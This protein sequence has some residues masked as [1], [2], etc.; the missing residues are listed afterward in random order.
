MPEPY[1]PETLFA[2][3]KILYAGQAV[4]LVVASTL[5]QAKKA[6]SMV[7]INYQNVVRPILNITDAIRE[8][9]FHQKPFCGDLVIGDSTLAIQNATHQLSGEIVLNSSQFN[10][11]LEV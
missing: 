8:N 10:F 11:Y 9:S 3:E 6:A 7:E 1:E 2:N 4:G 5:E